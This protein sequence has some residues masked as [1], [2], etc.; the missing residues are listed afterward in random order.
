VV[1]RVHRRDHR[2]QHLR[3]A[4]VGRGLL[5]ADVLLAGLQRQAQRRLAA[6]YASRIVGGGVLPAEQLL[7]MTLYP[8]R[9]GGVFDFT[10]GS[11]TRRFAWTVGDNSQVGATPTGR[12][13][14]SMRTVLSPSGS[15]LSR[16]ENIEFFTLV[17]SEE[18]KV[19][20]NPTLIFD[21][22]EA[23]KFNTKKRG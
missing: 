17:R 19:R 1:D 15:D 6:R 4:D 18:G 20:R 2:Q 11:S 10:P 13:W 8:L 5:A 21:F 12:R 23:K 3:S 7:W 16:I 9:T 22:G 14:R